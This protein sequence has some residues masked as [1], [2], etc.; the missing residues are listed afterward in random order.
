MARKARAPVSRRGQAAG[1]PGRNEMETD[2]RL[3]PID[4][5]NRKAVLGLQLDE[6]QSDYLDD[7]A[8]SLKEAR[9]DEDARPRAVVAGERVV[10]FL[11]YDASSY[12][13]ALLYRFM[14]DRREQGRGYGRAALDALIREV[15]SLGRARD[16]VVSYMPENEGAR[17][18]YLGAGFEEEG[19]DEDGEVLARLSL[20]R[21]KRKV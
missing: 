16:I 11:M 7:N 12:D 4:A 15:R 6:T 14:I 3:E 10:G 19:E 8:S 5:T 21:R 13:E 9:H 20:A 2:I 18:L 1:E 17:R